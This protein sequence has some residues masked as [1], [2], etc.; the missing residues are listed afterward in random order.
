MAGAAK[1]SGEASMSKKQKSYRERLR[2][3]IVI[4]KVPADHLALAE[5]MIASGRLSVS[6]A[7]QRNA[8][9]GA[10]AALLDQWAREV[11]ETLRYR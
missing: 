5:A 4:L 8:T 1:G 3:G 2:R 11:L 7:L 6:E 10:T 9:E